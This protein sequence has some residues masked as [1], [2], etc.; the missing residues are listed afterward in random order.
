MFQLDSRIYN[1]KQWSAKIV[2]FKNP[3]VKHQVSDW[4]GKSEE[5]EEI[6]PRKCGQE[7]SEEFSKKPKESKRSWK[8]E[9]FKQNLAELIYPA[10]L[11]VRVLLIIHD[12]RQEGLNF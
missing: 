1:S 2:S 9:N 7:E 6:F 5:I 11:E 12:E 8:R 4:G 3:T 10:V